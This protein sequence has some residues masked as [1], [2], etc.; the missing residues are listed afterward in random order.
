MWRSSRV[1]R[2]IADGCSYTQSSVTQEHPCLRLTTIPSSLA[3]QTP[4][5]LTADL[6]PRALYSY[7]ATQEHRKRG[8]N[9]KMEL[10]PWSSRREVVH[11]QRDGLHHSIQ[12]VQVFVL[13]LAPCPDGALAGR[14]ASSDV[15]R[16]IESLRSVSRIHDCL[17]V[18]LVLVYIL[19]LVCRSSRCKVM[20]VMQDLKT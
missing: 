10:W 2:S 8:T 15:T 1:L 4:H 12:A 20:H 7:P 14:N 17:S 18:G 5:S 3:S 19:C 13:Q 11:L 16:E 9:Q 6:H